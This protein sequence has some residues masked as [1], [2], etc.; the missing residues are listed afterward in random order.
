MIAPRGTVLNCDPDRPVVGGNHETSQR[1]VDAIVKALAPVLPDRVIAGGPTTAGL[2]IFGARQPDGRWA[3]LYE[4]H[5]GGEGATA[6]KDGASAVRV[7]MSNVMNTPVEVIEGEYPILVEEH[8]LR[9]GSAGDGAHRGGLGFRRAYRV[10]G[11]DVTLTSMLERRLV[12]P[13]G[14][15]GG[16]DG[17][18]FRVT[19]NPGTR[20]ER[21]VKGKETLHAR[22]GRPGR[23][24]NLRRRRLRRARRSPRRR[25]GPRRARGISRMKL[26]DRIALVT[27][28]AKGM[29]RRS[30]RPWRARAPTSCW[31]RATPDRSRPWRAR[32]RGSGG[33][34]WWRRATS[35]T[36]AR[37]SARWPCAVERFGKIDILVN[38]AGV[39]GPVETP[40]QDIKPED[41]RAV[42]ETNVVG[43]FL[44]IKYV[45][46]GM[47]ARRYGKIINI[48][49]S[50]GLRGYKYRTAYSSSKW[51]LRGLTRTVA[52]EAGPYNVNVNALHPGIVGRPAHGAPLPREGGQ[53]RL[54][55]GA[56]PPGVRRRDGAPPRD[57]RPRHR[58]RR[59]VPRLGRLREHDGPVRGGGRGM[60]CLTSKG[61]S[62]APFERP[63]SDCAGGAGA[64][65]RAIGRASS[66]PHPT[67]SPEGRGSIRH[68]RPVA[69][70]PP[71]GERVG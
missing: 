23:D 2:L 70:S 29:G 53:A 54:D 4:V 49:G 25:E 1:V 52:L 35:P 28:A 62:T 61:A 33:A 19:L 8:A 18:P 46:P 59:R 57:H 7:H 56:R 36:S 55:A 66:P 65:A 42:L 63:P 12:P 30:A 16:G 44:P 41:F 10:T 9:A 6:A 21:P 67:L 15:A 11:R 37:W 68:E 3:V 64:R 50:S 26:A 27:G 58:Q 38:A 51:A 45:L 69:P 14:L 39:T 20:G 24:R 40:V 22:R 71:A 48:S 13:Y 47:I 31:R 32:S 43:T 34:R 17:A 5:G 60:G